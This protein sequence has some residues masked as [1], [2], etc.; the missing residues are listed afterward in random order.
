M[1]TILFWVF[2]AIWSL[3]GGISGLILYDTQVLPVRDPFK[4]KVSSII[5]GPIFWVVWIFY[6]SFKTLENWLKVKEA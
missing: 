5:C 1:L 3:A 4:Q 2:I 6:K